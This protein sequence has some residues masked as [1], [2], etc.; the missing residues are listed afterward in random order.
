MGFAEW[1]LLGR[2]LLGGGLMGRG[3]W[4]GS[5]WSEAASLS[6]ERGEQRREDLRS[7]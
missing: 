5:Y 3:S 2:K 4:V 6:Q 1:K 7:I